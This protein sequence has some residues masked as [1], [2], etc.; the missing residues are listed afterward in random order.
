M[1][2]ERQRLFNPAGKSF[3]TK[4]CFCSR[5]GSWPDIAEIELSALGP[6]APHGLA[7]N[8]IPNLET[9]CALLKPQA[10]ARNATQ[11]DAGWQFTAKDAGIKLKQTVSDNKELGVTKY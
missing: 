5:H 8:R 6:S 1:T 10:K 7:N 11:R 4:R 3:G 9:L 2:V